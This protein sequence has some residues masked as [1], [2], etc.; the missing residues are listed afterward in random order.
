MTDGLQPDPQSS[1][2]PAPPAKLGDLIISTTLNREEA[3]IKALQGERILGIGGLQVYAHYSSTVTVVM[4]HNPTTTEQHKYVIAMAKG[5]TYIVAAPVSWTEY[6][7]EIVER[8]SRASGAEAICSGGGFLTFIE[9]AGLRASG[10]STDFGPA[11]HTLAKEAFSLA[12]EETVA[13]RPPS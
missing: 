4:M 6:H 10:W 13:M 12:V 11:D 9:G 3:F 5:H 2:K 8:V 1:R 7:R